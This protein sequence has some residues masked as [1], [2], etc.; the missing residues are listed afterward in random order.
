MGRWFKSTQ[1]S[2]EKIVYLQVRQ[3]LYTEN[4]YTDESGNILRVERNNDDYWYDNESTEQL[5]PDEVEN[6]GLG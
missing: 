2:M 5:S 6:L 1:E 4:V 3:Y